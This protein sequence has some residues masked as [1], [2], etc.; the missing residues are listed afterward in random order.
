MKKKTIS[1]LLAMAMAAT[2]MAGCMTV[3]AEEASFDGTIR[4]LNYKPEVADQMNDVAA[5]YTAETGID[6]KV[7]TAASGQY[8][9]TLT[10]RMDSSE[11]PSIFIID[12][13]NMLTTWKDY[14][15]DLSGTEL[16][17]YVSNEAYAKKD[18][19]KVNCICYVLEHWGIIVNKAIMEKY[20]TSE[21]K[22]T[23][24][25]SLDDL[26]TFDALKAVVEDMT[27][28]KEEL[29]IEGV[30]GST[31][32]K[33]GD[34]WRYQTHLMNIPTYWEWGADVDTFGVIPEFTFE[35]AENF[36]NILDLY[37][38][39][40]VIE[41][42]LV[43]TKTVDDSMAEF[44]LG[45]CAMIQN[46]DWA[47]STIANTEGKAVADEDVCFIPI[48]TGVEGEEN[49]GL[50]AAT[51]LWLCINN[52]VPEEE[53]AAAADFL[54]W[55][56]SSETGKKMVSEEL[57]LVTPFTTMEGAVYTN[58]LFASASEIEA[59]GKTSYVPACN[60]LP[61][62]TWKDDFGANL[63]MYAQGQMEWDDVVTAAVDEW[64]VE[65]EYT[66]A[67]KE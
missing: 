60:L 61:S 41:P 62:Q 48:T 44:A 42:K 28:M 36:K 26:Y 58:A 56:F 1:L 15:A 51:T 46:G 37:L 64:A 8:E 65:R 35:Y 39:N 6:V 66:N 9:A 25:T 12:G 30:F 59:A 21:N 17:S 32:L 18:G 53:Q 63:L 43:G 5:A 11:A 52:Q 34:D 33:A 19:D 67:A 10:A 31:A 2:T 45:K 24:Y 57:Q 29:G 23:E 3:N 13:G 50:S 27:S 7:E 14:M 40:S 49:M 54:A 22:S 4:W 38:N 55:L 16:Y 47:W 20:F